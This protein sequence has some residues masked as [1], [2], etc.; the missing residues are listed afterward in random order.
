MP[1][2]NKDIERAINCSTLSQELKD[3]AKDIKDFSEHIGWVEGLHYEQ[4]T[5][6]IINE[7]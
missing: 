7:T 5:K 1:L 6:E 2:T 4:D 3:F